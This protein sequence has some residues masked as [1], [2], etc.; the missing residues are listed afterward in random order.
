M[1]DLFTH[2]CKIRNRP[3]FKQYRVIQ[4][5]LKLPTELL[6]IPRNPYQ[7]HSGKIN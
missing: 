7:K 4:I 6:N 5:I 1:H 2:V 3:K